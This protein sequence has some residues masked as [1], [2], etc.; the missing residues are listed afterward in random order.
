MAFL[1]YNKKWGIPGGP[2]GV[3]LDWLPSWID[4]TTGTGALAAVG[5]LSGAGSLDSGEQ[6]PGDVVAAPDLDGAAF[7]QHFSLGGDGDTLFPVVTLAGAARIDRYGTAA[8]AA[9]GLLT[10]AGTQ[11]YL[12]DG[13]LTAAPTLAGTGT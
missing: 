3:E 7:L 9:I 5:T 1:N 2:L 13:T 8:L 6:G 12:A 4:S 11:S 10:G